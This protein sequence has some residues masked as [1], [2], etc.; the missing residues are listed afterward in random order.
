MGKLKHAPPTGPLSDGSDRAAWGCAAS[1]VVGPRSFIRNEPIR[2]APAATPNHAWMRAGA[3][4]GASAGAAKRTQPGPRR[5]L[6]NEANL[7]AP[8]PAGTRAFPPCARW[9]GGG[10]APRLFDF[11]VAGGLGGFGGRRWEVVEKAGK[12]SWKATSAREGQSVCW[13]VESREI[14]P[15]RARACREKSRHGKPERPRHGG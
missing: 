5:G 13:K 10:R 2:G 9:D 14:I 11:R 3:N 15:P 4:V 7:R 6:R 8:L 12:I 1:R